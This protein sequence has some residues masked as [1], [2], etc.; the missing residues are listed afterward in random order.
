MHIVRLVSIMSTVCESDVEP[1]KLEEAIL[2][3]LD[4][5]NYDFNGFYPVNL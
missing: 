4:Q 1:Y 5:E 3:K 2:W